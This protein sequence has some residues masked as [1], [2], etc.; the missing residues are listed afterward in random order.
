MDKSPSLIALPI[1]GTTELIANLIDL[2]PIAS[3]LEATAVLMDKT[4]TN[5]AAAIEIAVVI[6]FFRKASR[7]FRFSSLLSPE[8]MPIARKQFVKG[9]KTFLD[10]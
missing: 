3:A 6:Y 1:T 2:S 5:A 9:T 4:D 10:I 8:Q 7:D